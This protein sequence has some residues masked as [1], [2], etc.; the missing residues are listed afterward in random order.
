[1]AINKVPEELINPLVDTMVQAG[2]MKQRIIDGVE[3][4]ALTQLGD[5][6][7]QVLALAYPR[8]EFIEL[9]SEIIF[10]THVVASEDYDRSELM[11]EIEK[12]F[13]KE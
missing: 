3:E 8:K 10:F 11:M 13:N 6:A 12:L 1:M 4:Q 7:F 5:Y 9:V 2:L